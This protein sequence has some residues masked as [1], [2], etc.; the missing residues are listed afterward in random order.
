MEANGGVQPIVI[1]ASNDANADP[2]H[3]AL[4]HPD[5]PTPSMLEILSVND[6]MVTTTCY[7]AA[8]LIWSFFDET[9]ACISSHTCTA[10]VLLMLTMM[11]RW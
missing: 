6:V 8:C 5:A 10:P 9:F 7:G 1:D 2:I 4:F 11:M 3:R